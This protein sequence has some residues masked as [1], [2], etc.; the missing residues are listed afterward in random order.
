MA[1]TYRSS[2]AS[3]PGSTANTFTGLAIGTA[4][5]ARKLLICVI[6]LKTGS[7]ALPT[8][9]TVSPGAVAATMLG[10]GALLTDSTNHA[11]DH[12]AWIVDFPSGTTADITVNYAAS[13]AG[14]I[15]AVYE[16]SGTNAY[17]L[18]DEASGAA[19]PV[20]LS[21]SVLTGD[22]IFGLLARRSS[23]LRRGNVAS[24]T[25]GSNN[26]AYAVTATSGA[27]TGGVTSDVESDI[28]AN[29]TGTRATLYSFVLRTTIEQ[30]TSVTPNTGN[31]A[32]PVT[33]SGVGF[34][35][36]TDV[37][38]DGVSATNIIIVNDT[39][40]TC[41]VPAGTGT[42]DVVVERPTGDLTFPAGFTYV[43]AISNLITQAAV[44]AVTYT[45]QG[46][47]ITQAPVM[48]VTSSPPLP[49]PLPIIPDV[50]LIEIWEWKTTLNIAERGKEQLSALR[51]HPR[52][53]RKIESVILDEDERVSVY[54]MMFKYISQVFNYPM[55]HYG[56]KLDAAALTGATKL[57]FNP[58]HTDLR[59]GEVAALFSVRTGIT[60]YVNVSTV[61]ADGATLAE[62]LEFDVAAS[63]Y[64]CAAPTFMITRPS[65]S[66]N[67][68]SGTFSMDMDGAE[69]REVLRPDQSTT[70]ETIDG[71]T[72]IDKRPLADGVVEAFDRDITWLDN[73]V[74]NPEPRFRWP[75]PFPSGNR[76][77]LIHRSDGMDYWRAVASV[78]K[79]RQNPFLLP[80]FRNDLPL[81]ETPALDAATISTTNFHFAD[82]YR[83]KGWRY[84][85]IQSDAGVIFR[86]I[87]DVAV[88]YDVDGN[89]THATV[90]FDGTIGAAAGSNENLVISYMNTCRLNDDKIEI[91]HGYIDS[92]LSMQ[93]RIVDE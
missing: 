85:R 8:S 63:Q 81:Y 59:D 66:M 18:E 15:V 83:S 3:V 90:N 33:V 79:G 49:L 11:S 4:D 27:F 86:R 46:A 53:G 16:L 22:F 55:F 1:L 54:N 21:V 30:I 91:E 19:S 76:S 45:I 56:V 2:G 7:A 57:F 13:V 37:T 60:R 28:S 74:A 70:L 10:S 67:S 68:I 64:I 92:V 47:M 5:P 12:S 41:D 44:L 9:V 29:A 89:P 82:F 93:V 48:A 38:F 61:D 71:I 87:N 36:A 50:P 14:L 23:N 17:T 20:N 69:V 52:M 43:G 24:A 42:V 51:A 32:T 34:T 78:L 62:A 84:A 88:Q 72:I 65:F 73:G 58:A 31:L 77:Y 6:G 39:T 35:N 25:A 75:T 26:A 40:I 80:T